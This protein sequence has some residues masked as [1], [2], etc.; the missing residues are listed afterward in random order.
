V[1]PPV[2]D[3]CRQTGTYLPRHP[4]ASQS[5][6][7]GAARP[8]PR[9]ARNLCLALCTAFVC[10]SLQTAGADAAR[11]TLALRVTADPLSAAAAMTAAAAVVE[12]EAAAALEAAEA[13]ADAAAAGAA[14]AENG[15][16][17]NAGGAPP[18]PAAAPADGLSPWDTPLLAMLRESRAP[19]LLRL[20]RAHLKSGSL[21]CQLAAVRLAAAAA[22]TAA[23]AASGGGG[24]KDGRANEWADPAAWSAL[25]AGVVA[26]LRA[27]LQRRDA[28]RRVGAADGA[29]VA[30]AEHPAWALCAALDAV[31][32]LLLPAI[33]TGYG[34]PLPPCRWRREL[35]DSGLLSAL[36]EV[37][38]GADAFGTLGTHTRVACAAWG[39]LA[40]AAGGGPLPAG[41]SAAV[42]RAAMGRVLPAA[43]P[44][45]PDG[46]S[47]PPPAPV[48]LAAGGVVLA[49]LAAERF[50][51]G[52]SSGDG[53]AADGAA[54][55]LHAAGGAS[56]AAAL[57]E[58]VTRSAAEAVHVQALAAAWAACP[59]AR[60]A[61]PS[62][63]RHA[64]LAG[65]A[66]LLRRAAGS[67]QLPGSW[68]AALL[69]GTHGEPAPQRGA[70][71][72]STAASSGCPVTLG[73]LL[74]LISLL[75]A[76]DAAGTAGWQAPA[77]LEGAPTPHG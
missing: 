66:S 56:V 62:E 61:L 25:L 26:A 54:A 43:T 16:A 51:G 22:A 63:R 31:G 24:P 49:L 33:R 41:A 7:P 3:P 13:A 73:A 12:M 74:Q 70:P 52:G 4:C 1:V 37:E 35:L 9:R 32:R 77:W 39:A 21:P 30:S 42:A 19:G 45:P 18:G 53:S 20:L 11:A 55:A 71:A 40:R 50:S 10:R 5:P 68:A 76:D 59:E 36:L 2:A 48:A 60:A 34:E 57:A 75:A 23:G 64:V 8:V 44:A 29:A 72:A 28:A 38:A 46:L 14:G 69:P 58:R 15:G 65:A 67:T 27:A 47:S 17:G 6:I